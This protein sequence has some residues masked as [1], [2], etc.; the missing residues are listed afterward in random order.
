MKH[1]APSDS[2]ITED[3][4]LNFDMF[5]DRQ[6][7]PD[8]GEI[9]C[10]IQKGKVVGL[11]NGGTPIVPDTMIG[12]W[13]W[14]IPFWTGVTWDESY[15][16]VNKTIITKITTGSDATYPNM[17]KIFGGV[18]HGL[19][20]DS[21][22]RWTIYNKTKEEFAEV[23]TCVG[24]VNNLRLVH[25]LYNSNWDVDDVLIISKYWLDIDYQ[26]GLHNTVTRDDIVFHNILNDL[27][28]GFGGRSNRPGIAIG[29]RHTFLQL[30]GVDFPAIHPP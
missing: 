17:I 6:A 18:D 11:D 9:T 16:W 27:R 21:L 25:T 13:F 5:Y 29:Y 30:E 20:D 23:I 28:I 1:S 19:G 7:D 15:R 14:C 24:E 26:T 22:T 8:G 3:E 10:L 4:F 2:T 12:F